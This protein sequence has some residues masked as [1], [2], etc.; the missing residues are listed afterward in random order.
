MS[1]RRGKRRKKERRIGDERERER[2]RERKREGESKKRRKQAQIFILSIWRGFH[3]QE[4]K[5]YVVY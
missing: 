3:Q 5:I 2:E 1:T 4:R